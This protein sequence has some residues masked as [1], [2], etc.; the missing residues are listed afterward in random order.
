MNIAI[1]RLDIYRLLA[2]LLADEIIVK[3]AIFKDIGNDNFDNEVNRLL[4]LV[5]V[6]TRQ[7]LRNYSIFDKDFCGSFYHNYPVENTPKKLTFE[8]ACSMI[9]HATDIDIQSQDYYYSEAI[10]KKPEK[11][12]YRYYQG[13]IT[14]VGEKKERA[15]LNFKEFAKY[16]IKLS[17]KA[18]ENNY[19]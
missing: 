16:C 12:T 6:V 14:V 19:G 10:S 2:L 1:Y 9:I 8:K 7:L 4:I 5:A 18:M 17:N 15:E 3:D 13:I 11:A